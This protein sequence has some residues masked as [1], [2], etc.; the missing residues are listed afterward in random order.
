MI[1]FPGTAAAVITRKVLRLMGKGATTLPGKVAIRISPSVIREKSR[2]KHIITITGTNGKT[3]TSH[4]ISEMLGNLGYDVIN[5][6]SGANLAS[7]I[8]TTLI[9]GKDEMMK[10][11]GQS[12]GLIYVLETDEAAYA[13]IAGDLQPDVSVITNLFRDQLDRYGELT[14]T[15][16]CIADGLSKTGA[17]AVINADDSLV[18]SLGT[19]REEKT[20]CYGM[21]KEDMLRNNTLYPPKKGILPASPDAVYCP[22]CHVR[23]EYRARSFGHL[24]DFR[25][26]SCG[27]ESPDG[28]FEVRYDLKNSPSDEDYKFAISDKVSGRTIDMTLKIP[29]SHNLYN[30]CAAVSAVTVMLEKLGVDPETAFEQAVNA[31]GEVKAAFGRMEKIDVGGKKLCILLVKNPVGF[32]RSLAFVQEAK[33]AGGLMLL[34]NS[35][36]ADGK[37]VSWIWDVDLESKADGLPDDICVSGDRWGDM[38]LRIEYAGL[39]AYDHGDMSRSMDMLKK[40]LEKC[41][42]GKC[43]YVMPNYTAMLSLRAKIA[44]EYGLKE[45]WK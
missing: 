36:T 41:P 23:Y 32:D 40:A 20:V 22:E 43:L 38:L 9:C 45:F 2:G 15:R 17:T 26:P 37:D 33:D 28:R 5:N 11:Q 10:A 14:H 18:A 34:L 12:K 27:A 39:N 3:T 16:D 29:G 6:I 25:C 44:R 30:T 21:G 24:G 8:A 42:E 1:T 4:M 7:G 19:G 31:A 13:K 35:N